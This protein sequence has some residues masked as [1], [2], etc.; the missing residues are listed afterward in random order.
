VVG[1]WAAIVETFQSV[2]AGTKQI[3]MLNARLSSADSE[4]TWGPWDP[5][6]PSASEM[7]EDHVGFQL[8]YLDP[9]TSFVVRS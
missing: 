5:L 6:D 2:Y 8:E 3:G 4:G 7:R 9:N 1:S